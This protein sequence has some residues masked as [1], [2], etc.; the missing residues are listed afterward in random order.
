MKNQFRIAVS[1]ALA[2][3][4]VTL[5]MALVLAPGAWAANTYKVLLKFNGTDGAGPEDALV[6]DS[7]GNLYGTTRGV[8]AL[9]LERFL[10]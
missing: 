6:F 5:I 7:S 4:S 2:I 3:M 10:N 1:K 8:G 9:E